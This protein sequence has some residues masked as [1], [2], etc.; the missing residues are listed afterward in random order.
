MTCKEYMNGKRSIVKFTNPLPRHW[1]N[2]AI[3]RS[4]FKLCSVVFS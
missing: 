1:M 3:D 4:G 2:Q